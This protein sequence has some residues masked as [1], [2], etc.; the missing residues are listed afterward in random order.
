MMEEE[1]EGSRKTTRK[2]VRMAGCADLDSNRAPL[3]Y[4]YT[5]LFF[6]FLYGASAHI[7]PWPPLYEVP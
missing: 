2:P 1:L 3:E 7:G 5:T 6:F 4:V